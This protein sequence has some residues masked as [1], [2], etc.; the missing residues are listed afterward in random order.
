MKRENTVVLICPHLLNPIPD[1]NFLRFSFLDFEWSVSAFFPI[2][3]DHNIVSDDGQ[4]LQ[5]T[6]ENWRLSVFELTC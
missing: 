1:D 2:S 5:I 3:A 4:I 6:Y